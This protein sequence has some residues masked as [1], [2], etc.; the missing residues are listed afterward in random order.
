MTTYTVL[1][2]PST[3]VPATG[4]LPALRTIV[5]YRNGMPVAPL[6]A[7]TVAPPS[8]IPA[9]AAAVSAHFRTERTSTAPRLAS[10][11]SRFPSPPVAAADVVALRERAGL[12]Q[13]AAADGA[14]IS[15][16]LVGELE[17]PR[18]SRVSRGASP[19]AQQYV[20][21]LQQQVA[22]IEAAR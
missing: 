22:R 20:A 19:Q 1:T 15:R 13:R 3:R 2:E 7:P 4:T 5:L 6:P 8:R 11:I 18:L 16:G 17:T 10:V 14:G 12:S 21:W 9:T